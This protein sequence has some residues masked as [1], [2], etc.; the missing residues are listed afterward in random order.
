[1][2][3][4]LIKPFLVYEF[5]SEHELIKAIEE[6]SYKFTRE[7]EHIEDYLND[8]RLV[9]AY[10]AFYLTTNVGKL[11]PILN[12][13]PQDFVGHLQSS[14]IIDMG[15]G[16]GTYSIAVRGLLKKPISLTQIETSSIMR[17]Q[18]KKIWE[19]LYPGENLSQ[20]SK[21]TGQNFDETFMLF[22]H[23]AN[24]MGYEKVIDYVSQL[25]PQHLLFIEPGTKTVFDLMLR[26]R[27]SL[28][29]N[30][31]NLIFPCPQSDE[32]PLQGTND[33]CH[34]Y[35]ELKQDEEVERISQIARK[36]RRRLPLTVMAFS[37]ATK[38]E[39]TPVRIIRTMPPTKFSFEWEACI[40][41]Q[42]ISLQVMKR[43]LT[44]PQIDKLENVLSGDQVEITLEKELEK[45]HRVKVLRINNLPL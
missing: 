2:Q 42:H 10:A 31:Y 24:E 15:A 4:S 11:S 12:W 36:D 25:N 18:A 7:R 3:L 41:N 17:E 19:G 13:L 23:S 6:I 35:I 40:N 39:V 14:H 34:Q 9:A 45:Y 8:P 38:L 28:I 33:W 43:S 22:G 30:N 20:S 37:K 29:E 5:K 1:M 32:C 27:K 26:V 21:P 44:K 16:P